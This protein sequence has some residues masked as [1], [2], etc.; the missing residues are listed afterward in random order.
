[1]NRRKARGA[2]RLGLSMMLVLGFAAALSAC[3]KRGA[4]QGDTA[5]GLGADGAVRNVDAGAGGG[6]VSDGSTGRELDAR[7]GT[8]SSTDAADHDRDADLARDAGEDAFAGASEDAAPPAHDAEA[9]DGASSDAASSD[10]ASSDAAVP[11]QAPSAFAQTLGTSEDVALAGTL[12]GSD[13]DGDALG[14]G[15]ASAPAHG[16]VSVD[17]SSG[18]F[19]YTPAPEYHGSDAFTFV[20]SDGASA[21]E[22]A[23]VAITVAAVNDAPV[24]SGGPFTIY[25]PL[26]EGRAVGNIAVVDPDAGQTHAFAITAGNDS[27]AFGIDA[28]SGALS[29]ANSTA[30]VIG[31]YTLTIAITD[32]GVPALGATLTVDITIGDGTLPLAVADTFQLR[33]GVTTLLNLIANDSLGIPAATVISFGGGSLGGSIGTFAAGAGPTALGDGVVSI[34]ASGRASIVAAAPGTYTFF[35]R[36]SNGLHTSDAMVTLHAQ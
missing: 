12:A 16:M 33:T 19:T 8:G 1:M 36:L 25:T 23:T 22:A 24:P 4:G 7:A 30:A 32:D 11:N 14:F 26:T 34:G 17:P 15:I 10:A 31:T 21:S 2:L 18:A 6:S 27:G 13:P 28:K 5:H 20:V 35:Y 9:S 3:S 29:I